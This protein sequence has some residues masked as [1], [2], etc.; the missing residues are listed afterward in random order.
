MLSG[1]S[2]TTR[3]PT[4]GPDRRDVRPRRRASGRHRLGRS[5]DRIAAAAPDSDEEG[6]TPALRA[7]LEAASKG[8]LDAKRALDTSV[9]RQQQLAT[10]LKTIEVEIDQRSGKVGEIAGWRTAPAGSAR[11]RRCSTA[12]LP[13]A[14]WTGPPRWTRWPPTRSRVLGDLLKSK[15]QANRTRG[16]LDGEINEQR[17]Q[18]AVMAKR[19]DQA[20]RALT[21]ATAPKPQTTARHRLQP[22]HL[23]RQ[24]EGRTAQL[25]R[26]LALRVVQR[27]RPHAGQRLH[28]P[29][30]PARPQ[31]GQGRGLHPVR[32]VPPPQRLR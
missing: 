15:D 1:T 5:P 12:T 6:G 24:R 14:S 10:Q 16:A 2:T 3:R 22:G 26:L 21:V 4:G 25:R 28:H 23:Q 17:K 11:C 29:A 30:H 32:L 13:K 19:K 18:V 9:Q 27:Q 31:P 7:Q 8:Y 20:E